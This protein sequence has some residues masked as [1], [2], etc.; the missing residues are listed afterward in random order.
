MSDNTFY[1][2][3]Q[4]TT[5]ISGLVGVVDAYP[6]ERHSL[7]A[8]KTKYPVETGESIG[9]NIVNEPDVIVLEGWVSNLQLAEEAETDIPP[10]GKPSEAWARLKDLKEKGELLRVITQLGVYENMLITSIESTVDVSTGNALRFSMTLEELET[11]ETVFVQLPP[12]KVSGP[13]SNRTGKVNGGKR[14]AQ[15]VT[16]TSLLYDLIKAVSGKE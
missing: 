15:E 13:A 3:Q 1:V 5:E 16:N 6:E 2:T 12:A 4:R 14:S 7:A 8:T 9:D 10:E 11:V